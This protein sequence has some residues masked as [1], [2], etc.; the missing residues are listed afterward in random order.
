MISLGDTFWA[1]N[2]HSNNPPHL[3]FAVTDPTRHQGRVLLVN[4]TK[5]KAG[6][7]E[8]C[9]L[10]PGDHP[11]VTGES[12]LQYAEAVFP[13]A[14]MVEQAANTGIFVKAAPAQLSLVR[15]ILSGAVAS[16]RLRREFRQVVVTELDALD[17]TA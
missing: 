13:E 8:S 2:P 7:D 15:R 16:N 12:V 6:S 14:R 1:R 5:R 9:I 10:L 11:C 17:E 3:Y 4:M